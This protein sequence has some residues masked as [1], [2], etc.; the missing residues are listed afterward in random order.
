MKIATLLSLAAPLAIQAGSTRPPAPFAV[1]KKS[2]FLTPDILHL[3]GGDLGPISSDAIGKT[4]SILA[5]GDA[6]T[7]TIAPVETWKSCGVEIEPGSKG[8]HYLGHGLGSSAATLSA[9]GY[10]AFSSKISTNEAIA[11]GILTRCAYMT[12]MLLTGKY[13]E[14]D[15]PLTP[16]VVIYLVLLATAFGLLSGDSSYDALAKVVLVVLSGHGALLFLNPR[17]DGTLSECSI[18]LELVINLPG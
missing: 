9:T 14:L 18:A 16:H 15:V 2:T 11:Y 3:R 8:E 6:L 4:F 5:V 10:L 7:S 13:T 1:Q 17:L 12:E